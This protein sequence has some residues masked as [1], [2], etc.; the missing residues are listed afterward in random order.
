MLVTPP[1]LEGASDFSDCEERSA[2]IAA[3]RSKREGERNLA[4]KEELAAR[5][6]ERMKALEEREAHSADDERHDHDRPG[7]GEI[8]EDH[9]ELM[10]RTAI[11]LRGTTNP[12]QL[13]ARILANH[14]QDPRF[15]FLKNDDQPGDDAWTLRSLWA[16]M[17]KGERAT[18]ADVVAERSRRQD[19]LCTD[20][21]REARKHKLEGLIYG[22]SE[23][24]YSGL[25]YLILTM[26]NGPST[27][28]LV[29][30]PMQQTTPRSKLKQAQRLEAP[31]KSSLWRLQRTTT[32][33]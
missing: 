28:P 32:S 30:I 18:W 6:L 16:R 4:R 20:R 33:I 26:V 5:R 17:L 9:M 13:T 22:V 12:Q 19:A 31:I 11:A 24:V 21:Q 3:R 15:A 7:L 27:I 8:T 29:Q 14:G 1:Q 25:S 10:T 2:Y 23:A